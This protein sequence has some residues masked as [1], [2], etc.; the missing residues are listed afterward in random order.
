MTRP[1]TPEVAGSS[2]VALL[3]LL[4]GHRKAEVEG[5]AG[6]VGGDVGELP[7]HPPL[8]GG[9]PLGRRPREAEQRHVAVVQV[10]ERAV[11][12]VD[13]G[14]AGAGAERVVGAELML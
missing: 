10:D 7:A 2:P 8:V 14:A 4:L 12:P 5:E 6:V 3:R 1:V 13:V 9:Q 11:E